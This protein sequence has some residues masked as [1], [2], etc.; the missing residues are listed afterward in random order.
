MP[1]FSVTAGSFGGGPS[2]LSPEP[3][4]ITGAGTSGL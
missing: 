3:W 2:G 4:N 1:S